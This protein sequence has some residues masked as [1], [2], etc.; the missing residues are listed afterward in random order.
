MLALPKKPVIYRSHPQWFISMEKTGLRA[1][2]LDQI[3]H[4]QWIP[5]W[6][7]ER[8]YSMIGK[9]A[10]WCVSRQR[11]WAC[12]SPC[13]IAGLR[14]VDIQRSHHGHI[15][16]LFSREGADAWFDR[17]EPELMPAGRSARPAA[18]RISKRN[19]HLDVWFD[20]G[21]SYVGVLE[22]GTTCPTGPKCTWKAA[23]S[24]GAGSIHLC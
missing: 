9:P 2:A 16:D 7:R 1:K 12:P 5:R 17:P 18:G 23:T 14:G 15:F 8:I 11:S 19:G 10:V 6:G 4:V 20:S 3:N 24:T 13:S 22:A 21:C